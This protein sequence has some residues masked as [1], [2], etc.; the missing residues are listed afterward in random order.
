MAIFPRTRKRYGQIPYAGHA[1]RTTQ[2][3]NSY[4]TF[5][6]D[7]CWKIQAGG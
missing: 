5:V 6:A 7:H 1:A 4:K 3:R 2:T